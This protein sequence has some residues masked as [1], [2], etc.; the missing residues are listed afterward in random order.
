MVS[1]TED[2][3]EVDTQVPGQ[4]FVCISFISPEHVLKQKDR[5]FFNS[6]IKSLEVNDSGVASVKPDEFEKNF[7]DYVSVN[8]QELEEEFHKKHDFQTTVRGVKVR[9]TY[10]TIDEANK[11]AADIQRL[12]RNFNVFVGQ[13]GYWLPFDAE[14]SDVANNEYLEK[15]LNELMK[16]YKANQIKKEVFYQ[17][18]I[19]ETKKKALIEAEAQK[20]ENAASSAMEALGVEETKQE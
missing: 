1:K 12:D 14:P 15:D 3:L 13:V 18:Q 9:G 7:D 17:E 10:N 20:A 16:H 19:D 8:S 4:N 2:Y 6:Y 11:R 5:F